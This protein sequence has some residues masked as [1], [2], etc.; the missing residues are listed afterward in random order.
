MGQSR[1]HSFA[2]YG[3]TEKQGESIIKIGY[4]K[5]Y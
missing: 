5:I 2:I 3:R 4:R 1:V